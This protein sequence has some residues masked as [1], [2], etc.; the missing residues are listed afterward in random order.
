M[1]AQAVTVLKLR[2]TVGELISNP[3]HSVEGMPE[4]RPISQSLDLA[5][6]DGK[7]KKKKKKGSKGIVSHC[8]MHRVNYTSE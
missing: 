5:A 1:A 4:G 6:E 7:K 8:C 3:K 2:K